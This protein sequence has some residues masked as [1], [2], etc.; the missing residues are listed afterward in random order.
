MS[1]SAPVA[2]APQPG[3]PPVTGTPA[4][5]PYTTLEIGT[6]AGFHQYVLDAN[7]RKIAAVWGPTNEKVWT[8]ALFAG[9]ARMLPALKALAEQ[10]QARIDGDPGLS[11]RESADLHE[12]HEVIAFVEG[13]A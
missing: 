10:C 12:A 6:H 9:S 5:G 8:A 7:G 1:L 4:P 2:D 11:A 3:H 13:R